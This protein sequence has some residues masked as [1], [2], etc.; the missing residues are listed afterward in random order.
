MG[1]HGLNH[2]EAGEGPGLRHEWGILPVRKRE[3]Y[4]MGQ[5]EPGLQNGISL[6]L[7]SK[8]KAEIL[9]FQNAEKPPAE[10]AET[11]C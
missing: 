5:G 3:G 8:V 10:G 11:I 4:G 2:P 7:M 9:N 1:L 6:G